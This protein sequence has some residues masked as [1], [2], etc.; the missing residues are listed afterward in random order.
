[1]FARTLLATAAAIALAHPAS[2]QARRKVEIAPA[3]GAYAPTGRLPIFRGTT[4]VCY[5][6]ANGGCRPNVLSAKATVAVGGRVTAWLSNRAAIEGSFWYAPSGVTGF[7]QGDVDGAGSIVMA[8]LRLVLN[9]VPHAPMSALLMAGPAVI[10][11]FSDFGKPTA[12]GGAVGIA[13]DVHP[14]RS[15]WMKSLPGGGRF[16]FRPAIEDHLYALGGKFQ[17]DFVFSLSIGLGQGQRGE[18]Q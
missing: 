6:D 10:Q 2:A 15:G 1:M 18:R 17:Q 13:L 11:R 4:H 7:V 8:D 5:G 16:G 9:L 14:M 3:L 12:V